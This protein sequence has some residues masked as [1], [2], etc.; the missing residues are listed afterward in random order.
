MGSVVLLKEDLP[1]GLWKM[2]KIIEL[3]SSSDGKFRAAKVLLPI[4]KVLKRPLNLLYPLECGS[5]Q[6][7]EATQNVGQLKET[8]EVTSTTLRPTRAAAIRARKQ[9]QRLL[10]SWRNRNFFLAWERRGVSTKLK[11]G[12]WGLA[13][14]LAA[15][16]AWLL[17]GGKKEKKRGFETNVLDFWMLTTQ[18]KK[19]CNAFSAT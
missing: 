4:K 18:F 17:S 6:E 3:I 7:I 1:R 11:C 2:G 13:G 5:V 16:V 10:S 15:G 19:D 8:V 12:G 14:G 9:M